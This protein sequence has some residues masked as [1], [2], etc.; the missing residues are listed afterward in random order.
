MDHHRRHPFDLL[1][2]SLGVGYV[3]FGAALGFDIAAPG[4]YPV[5][6]V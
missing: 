4:G 1:D 2:Q 6:I 3:D 5:K